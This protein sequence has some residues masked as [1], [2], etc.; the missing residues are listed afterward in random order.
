MD[1]AVDAVHGA[2]T[3]I[4]DHA[5]LCRAFLL[6]AGQGCIRETFVAFYL[7]QD[8]SVV[9]YE[10]FSGS[11][12]S[13]D[14]SLTVLLR[15]A[16]CCGAAGLAVAHNHPSGVCKPTL[17]DYDTS[18]KIQRGCSAVGLIFRGHIVVVDALT[19]RH[20]SGKG[21]NVDRFRSAVRTARR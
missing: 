1:A 16:L 19:A 8:L 20:T 13:V 10:E 21:L 3:K 9:G 15:T 17:G 14:L 4:V 11:C 12:G 18:K 5:S 6:V 7:G 2:H